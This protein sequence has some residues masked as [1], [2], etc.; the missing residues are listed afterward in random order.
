MLNEAL[1]LEAVSS[2]RLTLHMSRC[3]VI[4][5]LYDITGFFAPQAAARGVALTFTWNVSSDVSRAMADHITSQGG[6]DSPRKQHLPGGSVPASGGVA[7]LLSAAG[8]SS[9]Q[10]GAG[11][12]HSVG[13]SASMASGS[14]ATVEM[15]GLTVMP[16]AATPVSTHAAASATDAATGSHTA[17]AAA[18]AAATALPPTD[19]HS[20]PSAA[21]GAA[22]NVAAAAAVAAPLTGRCAVTPR[23]GGLVASRESSVQVVARPGPHGLTVASRECSAM[24]FDAAAAFLDDQSDTLLPPV[25][26]SV[27]VFR[28]RSIVTN[29]L[30]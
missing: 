24:P 8:Q 26:A 20:F 1:D 23:S 25:I 19:G 22:S 11:H 5:E 6:S 27:A 28:I 14:A 10:P 9:P 2:G 4:E 16:Q 7:A 30:R 18:P 17:E 21:S 12:G 29:L 15:V 13:A 3:S